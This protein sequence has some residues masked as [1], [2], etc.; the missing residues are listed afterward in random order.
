MSVHLSVDASYH[1]SHR[2][3]HFRF[4]PDENQ[5]EVLNKPA[6]LA[7]QHPAIASLNLTN[8][9]PDGIKDPRNVPQDR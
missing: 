9:H 8:D 6:S 3:L 5:S 2:L 7:P 4:Q 1:P